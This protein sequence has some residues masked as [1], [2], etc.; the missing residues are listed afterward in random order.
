MSQTIGSLNWVRL[1]GV[2]GKCRIKNSGTVNCY[3]SN[4]RRVVAHRSG[5]DWKKDTSMHCTLMPGTSIEYD[6]SADIYAICDSG[7][8]EVDITKI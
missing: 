7:K 1:E 4:N 6:D 5:Y 3:V 8:T 2:D